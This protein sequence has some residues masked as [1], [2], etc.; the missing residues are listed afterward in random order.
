MKIKYKMP[1]N[2]RSVGNNNARKNAVNI[3]FWYTTNI[4]VENQ[5][6][7]NKYTRSVILI[8]YSY[9]IDQTRIYGFEYKIWYGVYKRIIMYGTYPKK[10][11]LRGIIIKKN[12]Y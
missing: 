1:K 9:L 7:S 8:K 3:I 6:T 4:F 2:S 11:C 5:K 12:T 10:K